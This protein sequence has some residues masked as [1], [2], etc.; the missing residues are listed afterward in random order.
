VSAGYYNTFRHP[1]PEVM[2]RF[3]ERNVTTYR[4]DLAGGVS[5]YL[6]GTMISARPVPR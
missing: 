5:F 2:R 1:R 3:A 6:D 4:T